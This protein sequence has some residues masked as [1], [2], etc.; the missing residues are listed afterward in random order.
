MSASK[1]GPAMFGVSSTVAL[2]SPAAIALKMSGT[3][4]DRDDQDVLAR[5]EA[6]F[7]DRLDRADRHVVIMGVDRADVLAAV[8]GLDEAFHHFLALGAGEVA[9]LAADD[10][11][12]GVLGDGVCRS[13]SCG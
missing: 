13:P 8:F 11:E 12:V 9:G 2:A 7:L 4:I 3:R 10:L 6:G 5:L 1:A